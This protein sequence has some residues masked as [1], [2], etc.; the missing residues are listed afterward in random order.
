MN[1][2]RTLKNN[3]LIFILCFL[4]LSMPGCKDKKIPPRDTWNILWIA[5]DDL[6]IKHLGCYGYDR[7][8]STNIDRLAKK[9]VRFEFCITQA[10]WTLPSFASMLSSLYPYQVVMSREYLRHIRAETAVARSRDP[11]RMP[12]LNFHWYCS[13]RPGI[14]L[15]AEIMKAK[16]FQTLAWTNNQWLA[17]EIS[18]LD[19]G[20]DEYHYT[21]MPDKYYLPADET[22]S[23]AA[24]WIQGKKDMRWFAFIHLMDPHIP[25]HD[26]PGIDLG[27]RPID[28]YDAE[29]K[30]MDSEMG[31]LFSRLGDFGIWD[32]TVIIINADHGEAVSKDGSKTLGHGGLVTM[33]VIRVPLIIHYPGC[34]GRKVVKNPVRNLDIVPT[35]LELMEENPG[36]G[37]QGKSLL[38]LIDAQKEREPRPCFTMAALK[39]PEQVSLLVDPCKANLIPAYGN[40]AFTNFRQSKSECPNMDNTKILLQHFMQNMEGFLQEA[41]LRAAIKITPE[42][43]QNL[44]SLGYFK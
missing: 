25:Y 20:F 29:I 39:G 15:F 43:K 26:H 1:E 5:V 38:P 16:G 17:P 18:G 44:K 4:I 30:F 32:R 10:P 3:I 19:R 9:G 42:Q 34:P 23:K 37:M 8:T 33:E 41:G 28:R 2:A 22:L 24:D 27:Q 6:N 35:L 12:E 13:A 11:Y 36:Q 21:D 31:A 40:I 7:D 14:K